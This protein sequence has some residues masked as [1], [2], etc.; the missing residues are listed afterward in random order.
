MTRRITATIA[1]RT[2]TVQRD[3]ERNDH[4]ESNDL[5]GYQVSNTNT[6]PVYLEFEVTEH[7]KHSLVAL[8]DFESLLTVLKTRT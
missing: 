7:L 3:P 6:T 1:N 8:E 4:S 2:P 5:S